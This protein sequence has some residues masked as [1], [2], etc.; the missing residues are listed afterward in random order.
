M[1]TIRKYF[2]STG[3]VTK[4]LKNIA[5]MNDTCK[6]VAKHIRK[7]QCKNTEY[8]VGEF[9][10]CREYCKVKD[11]TFNVNFEYEIMNVNVNSLTIKDVSN[12]KL[13]D[14]P[15]KSI[16]NNFIFNYCG[17]AHSFQGSSIDESFTIFDY[18][19][20]FCTRKWVWT[21]ITR[22]TELKHVYFYTYVE[23]ELNNKLIMSYFERKVKGYASQD[24][25]A[26][27]EISKDNYINAA[28]LNSCI[29]KCC[30]ECGNDCYFSFDTSYTESNITADRIDNSQDHNLSNI[31]PMC[32]HCNCCKSD[33]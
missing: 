25:E 15:L 12:A 18:N 4:S 10:I 16:R 24:R 29:N 3:E 31:Q 28:W 17:T 6:D 27:R 32:R 30:V 33:N 23:P 9:L 19:H 1:N 7:L 11:I 22:A 20:H 2:E 21:A 13:F 5:Y 26:N 8:E 14:V